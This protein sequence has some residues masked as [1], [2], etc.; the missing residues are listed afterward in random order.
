MVKEILNPLTVLSSI[1][2][3][4]NIFFICVYI[5]NSLIQTKEKKFL[6]FNHG[7]H[8]KITEAC[9]FLYDK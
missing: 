8:L 9:L 5:K 6:N 7:R 3:V 4:L 1:K 2:I